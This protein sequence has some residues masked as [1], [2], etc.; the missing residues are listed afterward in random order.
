[1]TPSHRQHSHNRG[2]TSFSFGGGSKMRPTGY[3]QLHFK[4]SL[5]GKN[6]VGGWRGEAAVPC[7]WY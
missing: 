7:S 2:Y 1:M 5:A 6:V 3:G 4:H